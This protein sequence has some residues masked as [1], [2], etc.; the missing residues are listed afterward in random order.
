VRSKAGEVSVLS[1]E[2]KVKKRKTHLINRISCSLSKSLAFRFFR[3]IVLISIFFPFL[4]TFTNP[5]VA[6]PPPCCVCS[7]Q[8]STVH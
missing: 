3:S 2:E 1:K 4:T 8:S 6:P 7:S 5:F